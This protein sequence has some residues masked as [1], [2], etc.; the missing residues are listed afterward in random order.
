MKRQVL[1]NLCLHFV[2]IRSVCAGVSLN[3]KSGKTGQVACMEGVRSKLQEGHWNTFEFIT[4][5][6]C[7]MK[8]LLNSKL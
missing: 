7:Y 5:Y 2:K 4:V 8:R 6:R 1:S 3:T